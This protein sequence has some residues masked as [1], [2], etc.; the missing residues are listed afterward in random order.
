[1]WPIEAQMPFMKLIAE[2]LPLCF[3]SRLLNN[4]ALRGWTLGHPSVL[5]GIV[6]IIGYVFL[7][8]IMLLYLNHVKKD[9]WYIKK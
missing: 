4:I 8:V 6:I 2:Y 1:M 7:H 5:F 3:I 9:A